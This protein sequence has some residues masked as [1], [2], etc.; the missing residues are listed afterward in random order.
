MFGM[1]LFFS[2]NYLNLAYLP[3]T[4][5][6]PPLP[7]GLVPTHRLEVRLVSSTQLLVTGPHPSSP[8][9]LMRA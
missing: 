4:N 3:L 6:P 8:Q 9:L 2:K 1:M 5:R 7:A